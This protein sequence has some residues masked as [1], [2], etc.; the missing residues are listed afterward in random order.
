MP[1]RTSQTWKKTKHS[2]NTC[3]SKL[4][5]GCC[6]SKVIL[7]QKSSR[8]A[9]LHGLPATSHGV[10]GNQK[11]KVTVTTVC[12]TTSNW[13]ENSEFAWSCRLCFSR[14]SFSPAFSDRHSRR[15]SRFSDSHHSHC[16]HRFLG[17]NP[18]SVAVQIMN[19]WLKVRCLE[20]LALVETKCAL[21]WLAE[22]RRDRATG[23]TLVVFKMADRK[24]RNTV[25]E[26]QELEE[27][28]PCISVSTRCNLG[29][30]MP[31][32]LPIFV[33]Q[34]TVELFWYGDI[35]L[36][37]IQKEQVQV[38]YK[39][40]TRRLWDLVRADFFVPTKAEASFLWMDEAEGK[41]DWKTQ[42]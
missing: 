26:F 16:F 8:K 31:L 39:S 1:T 34:D 27:S 14:F 11:V 3:T 13:T 2:K 42:K 30:F 21:P 37:F 15:T 18:D 7:C 29:V 38:Q 20:V 33:F 35:D 6:T 40:Y 12:V 32:N 28:E 17:Q 22:H 4:D 41:F 24:N 25:F 5:F 23:Y 19:S 9:L 36:W 10:P